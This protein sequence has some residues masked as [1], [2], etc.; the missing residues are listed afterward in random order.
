VYNGTASPLRVRNPN[1]VWE[2][3][4]TATIISSSVKPYSGYSSQLALT[5]DYYT[6]IVTFYVDGVNYGTSSTAGYGANPTAFSVFGR[7]DVPSVN[8]NGYQVSNIAIYKAALNKDQ[9]LECYNGFYPKSSLEVF[10]PCTDASI[11]SGS[12]LLNLAT[13]KA[14]LVIQSPL[15]NSGS[16]QGDYPIIVTDTTYTLFPKTTTVIF[17]PPSACTVT[18][19]N[20]AVYFG[21]TYTFKNSGS[22]AID[23]VTGSIVPLAGGSPTTSILSG[24]AGKYAVLQSNGTNWEIIQSN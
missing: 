5:Y 18:L 11:V 20:P 7:Q 21:K 14:R 12:S 8:A 2:L 23:N 17:N 9:I 24:S 16:F 15:I 10:S 4:T 19:P 6:D 3:A 13:S 1:L 22:Y